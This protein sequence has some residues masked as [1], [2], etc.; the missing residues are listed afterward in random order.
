MVLFQLSKIIILLFLIFLTYFTVKIYFKLPFKRFQ[1]LT[2]VI[3]VFIIFS[4]LLAFAV[5]FDILVV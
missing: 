1:T 3:L 5:S 4:F 2:D